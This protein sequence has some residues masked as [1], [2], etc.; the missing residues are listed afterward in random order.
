MN[1][2]NN[3]DFVLPSNNID[4]GEDYSSTETVITLK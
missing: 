4:N 2:N 1:N 3:N